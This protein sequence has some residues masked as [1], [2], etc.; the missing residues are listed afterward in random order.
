LSNF[1]G[2]LQR[3]SFRHIFLFENQTDPALNKRTEQFEPAVRKSADKKVLIKN[4]DKKVLIKTSAQKEQIIAYLTDHPRAAAAELCE[5][6][7]VKP[8]R[9][10]NLLRELAAEDIVVAEGGNRNRAYR[11][12]A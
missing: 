5:L 11:L 1:W 8:T 3:G 10:R 9:V 4:A 2:S 6:L 7:D 12:K